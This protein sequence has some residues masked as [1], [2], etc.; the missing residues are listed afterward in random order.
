MLYVFYDKDSQI[1]T[2]NSNIGNFEL[3]RT[4][5]NLSLDDIIKKLKIHYIPI[6]YNN[7]NGITLSKSKKWT[8]GN[9]KL[10]RILDNDIDISKFT[11]S[12]N[13][14]YRDIPLEII[15]EIFLY[16]TPEVIYNRCTRSKYLFYNI[17]CNNMFWYLYIK[18]TISKYKNIEYCDSL[19]YRKEMFD[20][21]RNRKFNIG[22][23]TTDF[24]YFDIKNCPELYHYIFYTNLDNYIS[25]GIYE[26]IFIAIEKYWKYN[27]YHIADLVLKTGI[28]DLSIK[29]IQK[30][31]INKYNENILKDWFKSI[32]VGSNINVVKY[33]LETFKSIKIDRY[34]LKISKGIIHE[35]LKYI[36]Y[37][38]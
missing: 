38:Q 30:F 6:Y 31:V 34:H 9:R 11:M 23:I 28:Y 33:F 5:D 24:I 8:Y 32:I 29:V 21:M 14:I 22:K 19:Y 36:L 17:Y 13:F 37:S 35:Y 25:T 27:K 26:Y 12:D 16:L 4:I 7:Y 20:S 18:T 3:L 1:I 10:L 15:I 2:P